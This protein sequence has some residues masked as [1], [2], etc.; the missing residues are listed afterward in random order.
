VT[1]EN[2][3]V[4][5]SGAETE[6]LAARLLGTAPAR[7]APCRIVTLSGELG[8]GKSTFA[9]GA[10]RALGVAGAIKSPTYTLLETYELPGVNVVHLDLYRLKD[11]GELENLGLADY[12][13]PGQLW[14]IE[15]PENGV[16]RL[17]PPDVEFKFSIGSGGHRIERIET[18]RPN[19]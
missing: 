3:W 11:P 6:A 19:K 14:L 1:A 4:T 8:S 16:G 13:R 5:R 17:P 10:L 12:D 2:A 9:R 18:F 15:W 7:G